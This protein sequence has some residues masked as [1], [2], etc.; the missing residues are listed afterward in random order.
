MRRT[1]QGI[2]W[3]IEGDLAQ[4][5]D[6]LDHGVLRAILR[7]QIPDKRFLRI[8]EHL[9]KA[10][11]L[12]PWVDHATLPGAPQG[13]V[14]SPLLSN[15][16]LDRWAK[17]V[18]QMLR[19]RDTTGQVSRHHRADRRQPAEAARLESRG[20]DAAANACR[21][22]R[23]TLP[24]GAPQDPGYRRLRDVRSAD[25]VLLGFTGP[26]SE[27]VAIKHQLGT[28]LRAQ[29]RLTLAEEKTLLTHG[30][31][32]AARF[33]GYDLLVFHA[34]HTRDQAGRRV[35]NGQIG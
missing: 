33:L 8:I 34:D 23:R 3:C 13:G 4:C 5:F 9:L 22:Q 35:L 14:V 2:V 17:D 24:S 27:A 26:R 21:Q 20:H 12:E 30:R 10:G 11:D 6:S 16:D 29:L 28:C 18:E 32:A 25:D 15:I 19:P 31:T 1:W 7:E